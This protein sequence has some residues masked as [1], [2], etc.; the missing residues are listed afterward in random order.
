MVSI[1]RTCA[2]CLICMLTVA[3]ANAQDAPMV[4]KAA[5]LYVGDGQVVDQGMVVIRDGR[6]IAAG[7][8]T[9][10]PDG[11]TV[12]DVASGSITPGLIDA[13][14]WIE[15]T[16]TVAPPPPDAHTIVHAMF[17]PAGHEHRMGCCGSTCPQYHQHADGL[18]CPVCGFPDQRPDFAVGVQSTAVRAEQSSE[19]IPHTR[20]IDTVNL[21]SPDFD[22]LARGGVTTVYVSPDTAAV[23]S[24]RGAIVHT[25]GARRDR[26]VREVDAVQAAIGVDPISRG[27]RNRQPFGKFLTFNT[28][29]PTTRMGVTWV[30]RK[31]LYDAR[32]QAAGFKVHGA[33]TATPP[34]LAALH[35]VLLGNIPLRIQ[36]R[37]QNDIVAALRL[38]DEFNVPF[39]LEEA[40]EAYLCLDEIKNAD[41]AVIFG[42]V[43][44]DATGFR[45]RTG[46]TERNRLS[47][48]KALLDAGIMTALT[49][50]ELR[51]ESGLA[52]Q[53][54]YAMRNGVALEHVLPAVTAHPA[55]LLGL[56][57]EMGTIATGRRA[58]VVVWSGAPFAADSRPEVVLIGGEVVVDRRKK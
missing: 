18:K 49:A 33:D 58:D 16:D 10:V 23:I 44:I 31:A 37:M 15:P 5:H 39:V 27:M 29:R 11:A 52:R 9:S 28:R 13:N 1:S 24:S 26:I 57:D 25:A 35:E 22:R 19:V 53:A 45:A 46:E 6:I 41:L 4:I 42:P 3:P 55:R 20:V 43:Y 34:A 2:V 48:F 50:H 56:E 7:S 30:F 32:R 47:T 14:A 21:R 8:G 12:I 54:M 36:A 51:D 17:H 40:T 38:S